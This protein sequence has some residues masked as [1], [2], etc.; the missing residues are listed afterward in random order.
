M[1]GPSILLIEALALEA[2][3]APELEVQLGPNHG[4]VVP[5]APV[6]EAKAQLVGQHG[7]AGVGHAYRTAAQEGTVEVVAVAVEAH[8]QTFNRGDQVVGEGVRETAARRPADVRSAVVRCER[9]RAKRGKGR[10]TA[11]A[12]ATTVVL[13]AA[14]AVLWFL[15]VR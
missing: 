13:A 14:A 5:I 7:S 8:V 2:E 4:E 15:F 6:V 10:G 9:E 3:Q 11:W 1:A 12:V